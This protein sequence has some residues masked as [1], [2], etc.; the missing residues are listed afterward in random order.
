MRRHAK[1]AVLFLILVVI[2]ALATSCASVEKNATMSTGDEF[3]YECLY[4]PATGKTRITWRS[5]FNNQSIYDITEISVRF[6]VYKDSNLTYEAYRSDYDFTIKHGKSNVKRGTFYVDGEVDRIEYFAWHAEF[7]NLWTAY[8]WW[9][10]GTF[11]GIGVIIIAAIICVA[12]D[13]IGD[14][15]DAGTWIFVFVPWIIYGVFMAATGIGGWLQANWVAA[16]IVGGGILVSL[17][18]C[19]AIRYLAEEVF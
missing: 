17:I 1:S 16:C 12:L 2:L 6:D 13:I 19:A 9:W 18:I 11:I 15:E 5:K 4:N 3:S 10:I 7:N 8:K 14:F